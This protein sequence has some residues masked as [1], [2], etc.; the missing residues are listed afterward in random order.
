MLEP[1][2]QFQSIKAKNF[3]IEV[4]QSIRFS[5]N[6]DR[7]LKN[8]SIINVMNFHMHINYLIPILNKHHK[9]THAPLFFSLN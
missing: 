9:C 6:V 4:F 3:A 5:A 7:D 2:V 1:L 8:K